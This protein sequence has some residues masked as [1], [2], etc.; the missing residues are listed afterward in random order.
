VTEAGPGALGVQ[1]MSPSDWCGIG[2]LGGQTGLI[3]DDSNGCLSPICHMLMSLCLVATRWQKEAEVLPSL[4]VSSLS[5]G[6][7]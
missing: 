5:R 4:T 6:C 2:S 7:K 3:H 1:W